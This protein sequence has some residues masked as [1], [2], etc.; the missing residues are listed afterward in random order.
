MWWRVL[1]LAYLLEHLPTKNLPR[2]PKDLLPILYPVVMATSPFYFL[3]NDIRIVVD[4]VPEKVSP[5]V[6]SQGSVIQK[7][8]LVKF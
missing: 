1:Q 7:D 5:P 4:V 8:H 6:H 2:D 3:V